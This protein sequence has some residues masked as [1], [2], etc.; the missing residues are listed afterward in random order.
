MRIGVVGVNFHPERV[1]IGVYTHDMCRFFAEAGH[2]VSVI[3]GFPFYP[4][5]RPDPQYAGR[6][7]L[8]EHVDGITVCRCFTY[9]PKRWSVAGRILH[10]LSFLVSALPRLLALP[11]QDVLVVVSPPFLP[12]VLS[13]LVARFRGIPV[14]VH[15]QDLQP[16]A[17]SNLG[18]LR[19]RFVLRRLYHAEHELYR[20]AALVS[21]LDESMCARIVNKGIAAQKVVTFPNWVD[22][23]FTPVSDRG[24]PFRMQNGFGEQFLVV[25][26]GSM[27]LK[28]GLE[29]MLE[30][31][32]LAG[33][34]SDV[35]FVLMGDGAARRHLE[36]VAHAR[37]L[38]NVT[39]LPLQ[40]LEMFGAAVA[41]S[42]ISFIPQR[43]EVRDLVV[44]SK[45]LRIL[46]NGSPI[47]AAAHPESGL[48]QLV[49]QSGAGVVV[50]RDDPSVMWDV[51]RELRSNPARRMGMG[52][53]GRAYAAEHFDRR[54]VLGDYLRRLGD[55]AL[56][57]DRVAT[58]E[59]SR[60]GMQVTPRRSP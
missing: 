16:D 41:A 51:I 44:P 15:I 50:S 10:E 8:T 20:R 2:R 1:G 33:Q 7:F 52:E 28:Q 37:G 18:M 19:N 17:A 32:A 11:K 6:W 46:A 22:V 4:E 29:L 30:V 27:G 35:R 24:A 59:G 54:M 55:V 21:A 14:A 12:A 43:P 53:R 23:N 45:V 5:L 42:D 31:A 39:F 9:V 58:D 60:S 56:R 25:Y 34:D 47:V 40:P 48:A 3:T 13:T 36:A 57:N 49:R 26:S 38:T